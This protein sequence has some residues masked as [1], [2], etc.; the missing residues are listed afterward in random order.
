MQ[1]CGSLS[2]L[3]HCLSLGLEGKLAFTSLVVAAKFSKFAGILGCTTFTASSFR[4]WNSSTGISSP[5]LA[6]FVVMLPKAHLTSHSRMSGST[7]VI[8]SSWLSGSWRS[9]FVL[10]ELRIWGCPCNLKSICKKFKGAPIYVYHWK[11]K[12]NLCSSTRIQCYCAIPLLGLYPE[13]T[14][15][16]KDTCTPMFIAALFTVAKTWKQFKYPS[17][18]EWIKMMW[19]IYTMEHCSAIKRMK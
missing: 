17:T 6:L 11:T 8:T 1:L 14:I 13:K 3:W 9:F 5:P 16:W 18:E 10:R 4:I 15:I 19:H 2:I 7:W 12:V